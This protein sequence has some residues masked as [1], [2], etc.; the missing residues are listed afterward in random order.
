MK[1]SD[2]ECVVFDV[3]TTGL[4]PRD[5]DRIIEIAAVKV[6]NNEI[7]DTFDQLIN[8]E[9]DIPLEA[10]QVN[11]ISD[12]MV[13][14]APTAEAV[15]PQMLDFIGGASLVGHNVK[16]DLEF[17]CYQLAQ[18]GRRLRSTTPTIDTLKMSR[19][20]IPH[21]NRHRLANV[22]Q[23]FGVTIGETHRALADVK[24]TVAVLNRLFELAYEQGIQTPADIFK[25]FGVDK[26]NYKV[27]DVNQGSLF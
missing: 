17:L 14:D 26:P 23:Y 18:T 13:A 8:P 6:R 7:I 21:L 2:I 24:L 19:A 16:F 15:L 11:N 22:A 12:A 27:E 5:G 3:E 4:Y 25:Q 9:R 20:L 1:P 10:Q